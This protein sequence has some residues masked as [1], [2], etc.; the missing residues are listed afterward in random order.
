MALFTKAL[1]IKQ[2]FNHFSHRHPLELSQLHEEDKAICSGFRLHGHPKHPLGLFYSPPYSDGEFT[3][4]ACGHSGH[5][6]TYHC[7]TCKFDLHVECAS[8]PQI[9]K[10]KDHKHPLE[11]L[12][13][14]SDELD[15]SNLV[16]YVCN[17]GM[18]KGCWIYC[19][20][21]CK[22]GTHLECGADH[23]NTV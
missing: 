18:V 7:A 15:D 13:G 23:G 17:I 5:G 1:P 9:E 2:Q 4:D 19:C 6:F 21:G 11:L 8:L 16:C 12:C 3:C 14:F 10:R 22:I 20:L